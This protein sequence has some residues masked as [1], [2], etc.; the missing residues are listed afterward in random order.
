MCNVM[1][2]IESHYK[3][4]HDQWFAVSLLFSPFHTAGR[5]TW[6]GDWLIMTWIVCY[7]EIRLRCVCNASIRARNTV[8]YRKTAENKLN[9]LLHLARN[10]I[11]IKSN[12]ITLNG[13]IDSCCTLIDFVLPLLCWASVRARQY[14]L[15]T[16][17]I[18]ALITISR[19]I[20]IDGIRALSLWLLHLP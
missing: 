13:L 15:I 11:K 17:D 10:R 6:G 2:R 18:I 19:T 8:E 16:L 3:F 12:R 1:L 4:A 20:S 7:I 9:Y 5:P 14:H